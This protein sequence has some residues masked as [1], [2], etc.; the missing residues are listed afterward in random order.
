M[1]LNAGCMARALNS[2]PAVSEIVLYAGVDIARACVRSPGRLQN[3]EAECWAALSSLV[4]TTG[5]RD[6]NVLQYFKSVAFHQWLFG[7]EVAGMLRS[8]RMSVI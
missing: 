2:A 1:H 5:K 7:L 6:A 8:G 4:I 3:D